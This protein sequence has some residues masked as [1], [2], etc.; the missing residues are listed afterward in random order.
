MASDET[1][2]LC[3]SERDAVLTSIALCNLTYAEIA[4]R[5]GVSKQ[6][7]HK[8]TQTGIPGRR[9]RAFCNATGSLLVQQ[10]RSLQTAL[11]MTQ[12]RAREADRIA[13]IASYSQ[14]AAA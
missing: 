1:L 3:A 9:E 14:S 5:C 12:G 13:V 2:R 8:W 6:A 7:V 11:R 4:A 10:Y